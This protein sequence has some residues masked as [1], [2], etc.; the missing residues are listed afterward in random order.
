MT[1]KYCLDKNTERCTMKPLLDPVLMLNEADVSYLLPR[2]HKVLGQC[3]VTRTPLQVTHR[4]TACTPWLCALH[5]QS[6]QPQ[7]LKLLYAG[8][9]IVTIAGVAGLYKPVRLGVVGF[10][11]LVVAAYFTP[12]AGLMPTLIMEAFLG[13]YVLFF[14]PV[15]PVAPLAVTRPG[16]VCGRGRS[17]ELGGAARCTRRVRRSCSARAAGGHGEGGQAASGQEGG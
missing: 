17:E 12:D 14:D 10:I 4:A 7:Y 11:L 16:S 9:L 8:G 13:I 15:R 6:F 3:A 1:V 2:F 5:T